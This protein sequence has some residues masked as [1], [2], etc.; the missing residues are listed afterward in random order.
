MA[1]NGRDVYLVPDSDLATNVSVVDATWELG[2]QL[3][4]RGAGLH[5]VE[6]PPGDDGS[7]RGLD[8]F[9]VAEGKKAFEELM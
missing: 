2:W 6:L 9:L 7:K 8:D 5:I 3:C 4:R 1:W